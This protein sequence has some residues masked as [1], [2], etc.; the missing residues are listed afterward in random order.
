MK[1]R[2]FSLRKSAQGLLV[3]RERNSAYSRLS[4]FERNQRHKKG[5]CYENDANGTNDKG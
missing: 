5:G 2:G 4:V 1:H 3:A